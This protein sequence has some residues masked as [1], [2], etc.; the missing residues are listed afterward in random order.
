MMPRETDLPFCDDC[1]ESLELLSEPM[2]RRCG[3]PLPLLSDAPEYGHKSA[4]Q[5][6]WLLSLPR[7][8]N[9]VRRNNRRR[10]VLLAKLRELVLRMKRSEGDSISLAVGRL[11]WQL[12]H[13]RLAAL[14]AD[15]VA[16]IPL[17]WRR[18]LAH[19]TN[20][21]A[22]LAEVLADDLHTP[23][24]HGSASPAPP[25]AAAI[26]VNAAATLEKCAAGLSR[27]RRISFNR[28]PRRARGRHSHDRRHVQRSRPSPATL[29]REAHHDSRRSPGN[30]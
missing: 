9:V 24:G 21:A 20:S 2:C 7:P 1:Y 13:D 12:R 4:K 26:G 25:Y 5:R 14:E 19:R 17:H 3:G 29:R 8:Q 18:R 27:P 16:P 22:I 28:R 23:A 30:W 11:I 10:F 15:V 6:R